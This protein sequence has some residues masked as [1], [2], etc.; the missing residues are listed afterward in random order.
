MDKVERVKEL[1]PDQQTDN[2]VNKKKCITQNK[3]T[4]K[5]NPKSNLVLSERYEYTYYRT[6]RNFEIQVFRKKYEQ[7]NI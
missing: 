4:G 1:L 5:D 7:M 2:A 3:L 6:E